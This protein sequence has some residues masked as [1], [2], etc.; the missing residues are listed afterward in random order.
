MRSAGGVKSGPPSFVTRATKSTIA[1][2]AAPSFQEASGRLSTIDGLQAQV[3]LA[4]A[5]KPAI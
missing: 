1:D 2:F 5:D 4:A 3:R